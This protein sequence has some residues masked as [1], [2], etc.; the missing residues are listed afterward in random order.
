MDFILKIKILAI[1][2][3]AHSIV[4]F[5]KSQQFYYFANNKTVD[6]ILLYIATKA[7][8]HK[9]F[10]KLYL[11]NYQRFTLCDFVASFL[12]CIVVCVDFLINL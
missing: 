1:F 11:L 2:H 5:K 8:R 4:H 6:F 7:Q 9:E 12:S 10:L 3:I